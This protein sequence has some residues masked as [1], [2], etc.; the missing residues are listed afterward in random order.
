[1]NRKLARR[2][3]LALPL[4]GRSD[5]GPVPEAGSLAEGRPGSVSAG[6][7]EQ[8]AKSHPLDEGL[9]CRACRLVDDPDT[10]LDQYR[11][12]Y[13]GTVSAILREG[14]VRTAVSAGSTSMR[15]PGLVG[16]TSI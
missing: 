10:G 2:K 12:T 7:T 5:R 13:R 16:I 8:L 15:G 3:S 11:P 1:M 6:G 4:A 9:A 14:Q